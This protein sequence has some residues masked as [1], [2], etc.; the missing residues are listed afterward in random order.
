M[1]ANIDFAVLG[2]DPV[3]RKKMTTYAEY[4]DSDKD[5]YVSRADY[6]LIATRYKSLTIADPSHGVVVDKVMGT[7]ST[8]LGLVGSKKL[9]YAEFVDAF[10]DG[11]A[12]QIISDR[13]D[14]QLFGA[15]FDTVDANGD[16]SIDMA[17]W[18]A[19]Y[20]CYRVPL[21]Y[22]KASFDAI[23]TN[24]DGLLSKEEFVAYHVSY[25]TTTDSS[26]LFGPTM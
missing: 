18:R 26:L 4:S 5:G 6:D 20:E 1:A 9:T 15:F 19:H 25:F 3:W 23:D 24:H 17:E 22:A 10:V 16:G 21:E 11:V 7:V 2:K 12:K 13:V 8:M 14:T